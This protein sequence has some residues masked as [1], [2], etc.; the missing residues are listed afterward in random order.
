MLTRIMK[1]LLVIEQ[2][3]RELLAATKKAPAK[4]RRLNK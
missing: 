1:K 4:K 3:L 2:L